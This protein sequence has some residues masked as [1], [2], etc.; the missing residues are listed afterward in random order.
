MPHKDDRPKKRSRAEAAEATRDQLLLAGAAAFSREGLA[1]ARVQTITKEAGVALGTFYVHFQDKEDLFKAV[2]A[3][4]GE[5]FL[6]NLAAGLEVAQSPKER[7]WAAIDRAVS[8]AEAYPDLFRILM[9]PGALAARAQ[10]NL[11]QMIVEVRRAQYP[12][13]KADGLFWPELDEQLTAIAETGVVFAVLT[14]WMDNPDK[15]ARADIVAV[16][17]N[18]RRFGVEI[19]PDAGPDWLTAADIEA[20]EAKRDGG[21]G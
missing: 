12:Q 5:L 8:F 2:V 15:A 13:G 11:A 21:R 16:L 4:G 14:W 3:K 10:G 9:S 6:E 19:P 7:D 17:V 18:L 20:F 1:G